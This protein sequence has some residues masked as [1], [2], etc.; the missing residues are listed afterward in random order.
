MRGKFVT[1][2]GIEGVGKSTNIDFLSSIIEKKGFTVLRTREPGGTPMAERIRQMLLEHGAEPLPDIA[3]LL[4]FFA[5]RSLHISNTIRPALVAGQWVVCD[6]FTD[7]S[8]AYQGHGRGLGL[9]R[10]NLM[11]DWVQEDLQ[12]DLTLL[13]DA[14]VEL[15]M[16]RAE[17]RGEADRL[18][19][20][21]AG[22]YQRVRDGYLGL[23][24][25][26]PERFAVIDASRELE[27][28][29]AA[30]KLEINRLLGNSID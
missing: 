6:R 30:I 2:E 26:E 27:Q 5:S 29:Q 12:P 23:A 11:A 19:S 7:A 13:L 21:D 14:P 9:E 16:A 10:I 25:A 20:Q 17:K 18:D 3:E 15:G 1:V 22:F 4:L 8:R 24:A 28:V